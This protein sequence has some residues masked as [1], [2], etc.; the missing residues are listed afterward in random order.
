VDWAVSLRLVNLKERGYRPDD[1]PRV[2]LV[3]LRD[4]FK[5]NRSRFSRREDGRWSLSAEYPEKHQLNQ[6]ERDENY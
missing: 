2:M 5:R 3:S 6:R 4:A 1:D